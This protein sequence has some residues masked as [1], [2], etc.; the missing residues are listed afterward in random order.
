VRY[1]HIVRNI[2][3]STDTIRLR[4]QSLLNYE[5][6]PVA[7]SS[8]QLAPGQSQTVEVTVLI[9]TSAAAGDLDTVV[10]TAQSTGNPDLPP[11]LATNVTTVRQVP[12]I[13]LA[14]SRGALLVPGARLV[15][16]H[17][18]TNIGN[19]IDSY[20]ISFTQDLS[21]TVTLVVTRTP[22]LAR[23]GSYPVQVRVTVPT[24]AAGLASNRIRI[25]ARSATDSSVTGQVV[26]TISP[27]IIGN[28][29]QFDTYLPVVRGQ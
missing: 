13:S 1:T 7:P 14:P 20:Q 10:V 18:V 24:A 2:G 27:I 8:V 16:D 9:P 11:A 3:F 23:G 22:G 17:Q 25:T 15:F 5:T 4:A 21:W 28:R 6:L 29:P 12:G 19:G 26:D